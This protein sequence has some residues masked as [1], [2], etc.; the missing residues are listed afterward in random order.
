MTGNTV[1]EN[2][3]NTFATDNI[4]NSNQLELDIIFVNL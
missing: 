3:K 4:G 2:K 1:V